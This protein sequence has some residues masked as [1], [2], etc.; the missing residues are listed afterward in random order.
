MSAES[1]LLIV[2][3]C[4]CSLQDIDEIE[5]Q[6]STPPTPVKGPE[7]QDKVNKT[8]AE[9]ESEDKL[10]DTKAARTKKLAHFFNLLIIPSA[11]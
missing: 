6:P 4:V 11:D 10:S 1:Y 5:E 9:K 8:Q 3:P 2:N 7:E